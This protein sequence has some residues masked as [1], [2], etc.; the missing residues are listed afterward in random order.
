MAHIPGRL[1]GG[2]SSEDFSA[3]P[4]VGE[5]YEGLGVGYAQSAGHGRS[6]QELVLKR[7]RDIP[8][9]P[10]V[11]NSIVK[12]LGKPN[13]P[14]SEIARLVSYDPGL[15]SRVL[16]MVNS[17]A[18]GIQRQVSSIQHGIMILGFN[19]VRGLVLSASIFKLLGNQNAHAG[20]DHQSFW[21]HSLA[22][23]M[24]AKSVAH[25]FRLPETDD[26]FSAGMLHDIGKVVLDLYFKHD[27]RPVLE[28]AELRGLDLHGPAFL[29]LERELM[30]TTHPEIGSYLTA[31]WK[32]P[33]TLTEVI[34]HHHH[35]ERAK[36][37]PTLV[38]AVA[39]GNDLA[40]AYQRSEGQVTLDQLNP[41]LVAHFDLDEATLEHLL[42]HLQA[43][44]EESLDDLMRTL[45]GGNQFMEGSSS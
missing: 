40:T 42:S 1:S 28:T 32:L 29:A 17:A 16:R 38:Y 45:N 41:D 8:S 20:M 33:I 44:L 35:P 37:C 9:L 3:D 5:P 36:L 6:H 30:G 39:L 14:A 15:T 34:Q 10:E 2:M 26:A 21:Y 7:I 19:T 43:E 12:Q 27:Y 23:A 18:Y 13:T 24:A 11:V 22:T 4:A 25:T 31:K